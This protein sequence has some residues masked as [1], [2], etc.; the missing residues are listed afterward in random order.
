[1]K[2]TKDLNLKD[3]LTFKVQALYD[4]ELNLV[5]ALEK[6]IKAADNSELREALEGHHRE[7]KGHVERIEKIFSILGE[8][9]KI[10]KCEGIR[11]II[12]DA[13][14]VIKNV[15]PEAARD[16]NLIRAAQYAEHYEIA[17]YT[18][19]IDWAETLGEEEIA[20]LLKQTLKEEQG[21]DKKL[22]E[23]GNKLDKE[24]A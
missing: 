18:G 8:K 17:G 24:I 21:G 3:L 9:P 14:W 2:N 15:C 5:K 19:A 4:I 7:T 22:R 23:I 10:L 13:E 16:S 1:M 20:D 6:M 12:E 11:G